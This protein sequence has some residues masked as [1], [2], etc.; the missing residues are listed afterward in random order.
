MTGVSYTMTEHESM[1]ECLAKLNESVAH[2][3]NEIKPLVELSTPLA[4]MVD[5]WNAVGGAVKV[6]H[7]LGVFI[8]WATIIMS[9]FAVA[10]A[11]LKG[12]GH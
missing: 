8:K 6:G 11:A 5:A 9:P 3:R 7:W 12:L 4:Q 2:L 10:Y 1:A